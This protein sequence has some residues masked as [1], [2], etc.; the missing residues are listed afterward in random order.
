MRDCDCSSGQEWWQIPVVGEHVQVISP[1]AKSSLRSAFV[2]ILLKLDQELSI[3]K[4]VLGGS[5]GINQ[6]DQRKN[7][8]KERRMFHLLDGKNC[9][10]EFW[11]VVAW[12]SLNSTK[13]HSH[14]QLCASSIVLK[15]RKLR[16]EIAY[17]YKIKQNNT[18]LFLVWL[19]S[20]AP[21]RIYTQ[22]SDDKSA[23]LPSLIIEITSPVAA[24]RTCV[25][26]YLP[27]D[28]LNGTTGEGST[29]MKQPRRWSKVSFT[30]GIIIM[31]VL[32]DGCECMIKL[33]SFAG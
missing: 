18:H 3:P 14:L 26:V 9:H 20:I 5:V 16:G 21:P 32:L 4:Q 12:I 25:L 31:H 6:A 11:L 7:K 10:F 2:N 22:C 17:L 27:W 33:S 13:L 28:K 8:W 19:S 24:F 30:P 23:I 29:A 15:I 1:S